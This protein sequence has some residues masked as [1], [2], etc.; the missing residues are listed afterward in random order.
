MRERPSRLRGR[1]TSTT[2]PWTSS[3]NAPKFRS[4]LTA[5]ESA[6]AFFGARRYD[7]SSIPRGATSHPGLREG[8]DKD[9]P[10]LQRTLLKD[11]RRMTQSARKRS[12]R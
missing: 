4:I 3:P 6:H 9:M 11:L 12:T 8:R 10:I 1:P 5:I 7:A 2:R